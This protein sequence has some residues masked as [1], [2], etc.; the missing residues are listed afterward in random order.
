VVAFS[1]GLL[2]I[3][4]FHVAAGPVLP[5]IYA[6]AALESDSKRMLFIAL[7]IAAGIL[8]SFVVAV[9]IGAGGRRHWLLHMG[10]FF[11]IMAAV[12][13]NAVLGDMAAQP[14]WFKALLLGTLPLQ[15]W[16]GFRVAVRSSAVALRVRR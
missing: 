3:E 4:L 10:L 5:E 2:T 11:V 14:V 9:I 6:A 1:L 13:L 16:V 7:V 12:D 8:G 15:L